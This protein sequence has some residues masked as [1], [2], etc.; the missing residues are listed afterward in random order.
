[1]N[2]DAPITEVIINGLYLEGGIIDSEGKLSE[3]YP[4]QIYQEIAEIM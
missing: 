2:K 4:Y 3:A 1:M